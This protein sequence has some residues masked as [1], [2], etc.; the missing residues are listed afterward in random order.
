M[1]ARQSSSSLTSHRIL[2][3]R[4]LEVTSVSYCSWMQCLMVLPRKCQG[5]S[6]ASRQKQTVLAKSAFSTTSTPRASTTTDQGGEKA[7]ARANLGSWGRVTQG[8]WSWKTIPQRFSFKGGG[9]H[10]AELS[11]GRH[12]FS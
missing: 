2:D 6:S 8:D 11:E 3:M 4:C 5:V 1:T 9:R 7:A 12:G 10:F